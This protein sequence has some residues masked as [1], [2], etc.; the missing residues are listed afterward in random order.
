MLHGPNQRVVVARSKDRGRT[1]SRPT[2]VDSP[3]P[4]TENIASWSFLVVVAHTSRVYCFYHKNIG[5]VDFDRGMTGV[6]AWR[7]SD[8]V[9]P[10]RLSLGQLIKLRAYSN[11]ELS[12]RRPVHVY[13]KIAADS[14][15][16]LDALAK[17]T[18]E[19]HEALQVA[20]TLAQVATRVVTELGD[21]A[22][23]DRELMK[24]HAEL[25]PAAAAQ[26][27]GLRALARALRSNDARAAAAAQEQF[28]VSE[29]HFH[30]FLAARRAYLD[31]PGSAARR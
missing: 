29:K 2:V 5:V 12:I 30:A 25:G 27:N 6:L 10:F 22:P 11:Y 1:W 18:I 7:V 23:T 8:D 14:R 15:Q 31:R 19:P 4:G 28:A 9:P 24:M 21:A 17:R 16:L 20:E 3:E 13:E 26:V